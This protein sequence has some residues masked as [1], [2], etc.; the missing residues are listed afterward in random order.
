MEVGREVGRV[1]GEEVGP[2]VR[3]EWEGKWEGKSEK[4]SNMVHRKYTKLKLDSQHNFSTRY[5]PLSPEEGWPY[6]SMFLGGNQNF[7]AD[8]RKLDQMNILP[9]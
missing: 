1:V 7:L 3:K 4:G 6:F 2:E 5:S 9:L 8:L